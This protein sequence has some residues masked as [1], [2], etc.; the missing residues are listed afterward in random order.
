MK[1][2]YCG[3]EMEKGLLQSYRWIYFGKEK[4]KTLAVPKDG[5]DRI[6]AVDR[7]PASCAWTESFYCENCETLITPL[8]GIPN[9][10]KDAKYSM[11][12]EEPE[13]NKEK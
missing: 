3:N 10:K 11:R 6:V 7:W 5:E 9:N 2:P 12:Y 13:E 4:H 8:K 1:C